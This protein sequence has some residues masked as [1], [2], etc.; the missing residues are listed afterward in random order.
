MITTNFETALRATARYGLVLEAFASAYGFDPHGIYCQVTGKRIGLTDEGEL[1][2][3]VGS[4]PGDPD[5]VIDDLAVRIFASMRPSLRWNKMRIDSLETMR[6]QVPT[7]TLAYLLNR[8]FAPLDQ[9]KLPIDVKL[10]D[11][12]NR[13][14]IFNLLTEWGEH[15]SL[16]LVTHMLLEIDA[17]MNLSREL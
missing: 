6:K 15:D 5:S 11:Y 13:I 8:L 9:I 1:R 14:R 7:E 4:I 3:L 12:H 10:G 17:K 2:A 16:N